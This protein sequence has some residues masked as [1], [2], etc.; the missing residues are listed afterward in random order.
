MGILSDWGRGWATAALVGAACVA[1][2]ER[3]SGPAPVVQDSADVEMVRHGSLAA[4]ERPA[5]AAEHLLTIGATDGSPE[6]LF[7]EI[8]GVDVL[9]DG[10]V[11]V[12][13]AMAGEV[14]TFSPDGAFVRRISRRGAGPGE[15]SGEGTLALVAFGPESFLVPDIMNQSVSVFRGDGALVGSSMMDIVE[16]SIREWRAADDR[17]VAVRISSPELEVLARR[18][19][20][21]AILDTLV[22]F[23]ARPPIDRTV[24][25][26][27]LLPDHPVWSTR[28]S[29]H[30]V[31]GWM[32]ESRFTVFHQGVPIRTIS[33]ASGERRPNEE[34]LETL[35]QLVA[36]NAGE[37]E[38]SSSLREQF[39]LPDRLPT[40]A[41]IEM[42]EG[43]VFVQ[44]V[45]PVEAMDRRVTNLAG[46]RGFGERFWDVFSFEGDYAGV[47]DLGAPSDVFDIRGDTI[48]GVL[49]DS[50][51]IQKAFLARL[52]RELSRGR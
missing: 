33:W 27:I 42:G 43:L 40:M 2:D 30:V 34:H 20:D 47:L 38:I 24:G 6:E 19:I 25:R 7:G 28:E 16:T 3:Q 48:L 31:A 5:Q 52:P 44:R 15:I 11:A 39:R 45:R 13:D 21:S 10:T 37:T 14:R 8:V 23:A 9:G 12:L 41:D 26:W 29:G 1:C 50:L 22:T 46:A 51:G 17:T 4:Y 32:S 36:I 35:L 49:E 18:S